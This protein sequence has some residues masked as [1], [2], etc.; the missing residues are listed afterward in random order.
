MQ[1]ALELLLRFFTDLSSLQTLGAGWL[2][3]IR[4]LIKCFNS[5]SHLLMDYMYVKRRIYQL[6]TLK[7]IN[8]S[9]KCMQEK[10]YLKVLP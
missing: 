6:R 8:T 5:L 7:L 4:V 9:L 3:E 10:W 2:R 1:L